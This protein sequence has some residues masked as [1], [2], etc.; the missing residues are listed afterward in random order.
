MPPPPSAHS[1]PAPA[2]HLL[3][4]ELLAQIFDPVSATSFVDERGDIRHSVTEPLRLS[5]CSIPICRTLLPFARRNAYHHIELQGGLDGLERFGEVVG[6]EAWI[7]GM[8]KRLTVRARSREWQSCEVGKDVKWENIYTAFDALEHVEHVDLELSGSDWA[9]LDSCAPSALTTRAFNRSSGITLDVTLVS[10]DPCPVGL[11]TLARLGRSARGIRSLRLKGRLPH[12][13]C[14]DGAG[15][16]GGGAITPPRL[17]LDV[18]GGEREEDVVWNGLERLELQCEPHTV[19][20]TR[21]LGSLANL[22]ELRW[23]TPATTAPAMV[24]AAIPLNVCNTLET[25]RW[26]SYG[27]SS[28]EIAVA[29]STLPSLR[30]L[31][32]ES[33]SSVL[34][35]TFFAS[36][37][38]HNPALE[39]LALRGPHAGPG[40]EAAETCALL[41]EWMEALLYETEQDQSRWRGA[42][43]RL[44]VDVPAPQAV[45]E[46][47]AGVERQPTRLEVQASRLGAA[48]AKFGITL[49]GSVLGSVRHGAP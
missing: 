34:S 31:T 7:G 39:H 15:G 24:A 1:T 17:G 36:L 28:R 21:L 3:P 16:R 27:H 18:Q 10:D 46:F 35:Q 13:V 14:V 38:A 22:K 37:H 19:G 45:A 5:P 47:S 8:V 11:D 44:E 49:G 41:A 48:C 12:R 30:S 4:P 32:I 23:T 6:R 9:R 25:L 40:R 42:M 26:S 29:F 43:R 33:H 20:L 2:V